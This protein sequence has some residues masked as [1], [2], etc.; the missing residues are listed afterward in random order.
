MIQ[1]GLNYLLRDKFLTD[2]VAPLSS[3]RNAQPGPGTWAITDT[4]NK[5]FT[6]AG[7]LRGGAQT[8][9]PA[10]GNSQ[11][12]AGNIARATGRTFVALISPTDQGA[13][14]A[15]GLGTSSPA[16]D[17]RTNGLGFLN[18]DANL[19]C[20]SPGQ[21]VELDKSGRRIKPIQYLVA[22]ALNDQGGYVLISTFSA[23]PATA[24]T[25]NDQVAIPVYPTARILW[26]DYS[27]ATSPLYPF[28]SF[29]DDV[30]GYPNGHAVED[31]RIVDVA[32]W[33]TA[34]FLANFADRF[35]R[36]DSNLTLG[37]GY[38]AISGTWG[39]SLNQAAYISGG[40]TFKTAYADTTNGGDGIYQWQITLTG[41][42]TNQ[43]LLTLRHNN[44][45][46]DMIVLNSNGSTTALSLQKWVANAFSSTI[47][48]FTLPTALTANSTHTFVMFAKGNKYLLFQNGKVTG[49]AAWQSDSGNNFLTA[50]GIG[51]GV[52]SSNPTVFRFDNVAVF[53]L[54]I[55]LPSELQVGAK[56]SVLTGGA[57]IGQDTFTD[58]N[59]TRLNAH[60]A[61]SG[62]AWT[63][64]VGTWTVNASNQ[65]S[66]SLA[67]GANFVTQNLSASNGEASIDVVIPVGLDNT[68]IMRA[69]IRLRYVDANGWLQARLYKDPSQI[70]SDEVEL[71][72]SISGTSLVVKKLSLGT[73]F[74]AST[75]YT[76]K[77]QAFNDLI[78]VF[79]DG[80]PIISYYTAT[81]SP[82][83][84][85]WGLYKET[86]DTTGCTFDNWSVKSVS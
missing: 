11:L 52:A 21:K 20:I 62:G 81:G 86:T 33:A 24:F 79:L 80:K 12:V 43:F 25:T 67:A 83:G 50:N 41:T 31:M 23:D 84:T 64:S 42:A 18:E 7:R 1:A 6:L 60:T 47:V 17:P 46:G 85:K 75:T 39:I 5:L 65:A 30:G 22:V 69:G 13:D 58:T 51:F 10:W 77:I 37:A 28:I 54:S 70:G 9:T 76:L 26:V 63:E 19:D 14:F 32:S 44:T 4:G 29:L 53:P 57:T 74:A 38:H 36:A 34:D 73:Y 27:D 3:P 56:P 35:T 40:G 59:G 68:K 78:L 66:V 72:E 2:A 55:T 45:T 82:T 16:G 49:A 48:N 71:I 15:F 61:E 8:S